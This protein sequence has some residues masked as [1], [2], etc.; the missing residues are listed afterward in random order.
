MAAPEPGGEPR[1]TIRI[2]LAIETDHD[3]DAL[4]SALLA[5]R[6]AE[7]T[8]VRRRSNRLAFG[9]GSN[10]ARES[11]GDEVDQAERRWT[12]LDRLVLAVRAA[13]AGPRG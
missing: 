13:K 5:A 8:Q 4:E 7:L 3:L 10:A 12:M 6:A 2:D 11:M 9:Y 1:R